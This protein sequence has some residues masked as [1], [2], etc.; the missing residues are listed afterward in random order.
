MTTYDLMELGHIIAFVYW[1]GGDMGT[2]YASQYVVKRD[3]SPESR[4]VALKI[5][6][7]C[8]QGP[9]ISMPLI[10]PL[11]LHLAYLSGVAVIPFWSVIVVWLLS[12][13]WV[14]MVIYLHMADNQA[15]KAK[16]TQFDFYF[17]IAMVIGI[18]AFAI[19]GFV[20]QGM[21]QETWL[22][23]KMIVFALLVVCGLFIRI[24]LK[25]FV[26]AFTQLMTQ[27]P[28]DSVNDALDTSLGKCRPYVW[29]IWVGLF[30]NAALGMHLI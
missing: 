18:T 14:S 9:K 6:L 2:F 11:G 1:L 17:R 25:P 22:S 26:P 3:I 27:G 23:Y 29:A 12:I 13:L 15:V 20:S 21:V 16:V 28:S 30:V 8:D 4:S 19:D 7:G 24:N 5:M 10:F